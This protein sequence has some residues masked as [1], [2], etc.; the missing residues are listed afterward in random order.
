[1]NFVEIKTMRKTMTKYQRKKEIS[2]DRT[3]HLKRSGTKAFAAERMSEILQTTHQ[4]PQGRHDGKQV[5]MIPPP[6]FSQ[7]LL[8]S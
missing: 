1:M 8:H 6:I 3:V 5:V 4:H 2:D 7:S